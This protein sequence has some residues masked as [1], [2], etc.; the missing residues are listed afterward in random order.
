MSKAPFEGKNTLG[1]CLILPENSMRSICLIRLTDNEL[2][3][4]GSQVCETVW[5]WRGGG[6]HDM[7]NNC[8][9]RA[10]R[11]LKNPELCKNLKKYGFNTNPMYNPDG[12]DSKCL[13]ESFSVLT[14][15]EFE[16]L[17]LDGIC[18]NLRWRYDNEKNACL[19]KFRSI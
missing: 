13:S 10:A 12:Y 16:N 6:S 11:Y 19:A 3:K 9:T 8:Y 4:N 2:F 17:K 15:A 18:N 1:E 5:Q 7:L 14:N